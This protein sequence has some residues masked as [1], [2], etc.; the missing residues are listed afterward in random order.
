MRNF[1]TAA[2]AAL[3]A[4]IIG[5]LIANVA[6]SA[7]A[8]EIEH[9]RTQQLAAVEAAYSDDDVRAQ[10]TAYQIRYEQAYK[11]LAAAYQALV[12]RE[13]QYRAL[14]QQSSGSSA[15][16]SAAN[17]DLDAKLAQAYAALDAAQAALNDLAA[18]AGQPGSGTVTPANA[19]PAA[20][21]AAPAAP[22]TAPPAVA[23]PRPATPTPASTPRITPSP[24][25][26]YC[27]Y[28]ADGKWVCEDHPKGQ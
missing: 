22:M 7:R 3:T 20:P 17:A 18:R 25:P 28:D 4:I 9:A 10:L 21:G 6:S 11:Q 26:T 13:A 12:T 19:A 27:W 1:V 23:T 8:A 2:S 24:K 14:W 5:L 16:L 15:Q